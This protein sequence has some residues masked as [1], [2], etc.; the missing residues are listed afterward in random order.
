M[1]EAVEWGTT[2][3]RLRAGDGHAFRLGGPDGE[4]ETIEHKI[5]EH[6]LMIDQRALEA[7]GLPDRQ[8]GMDR[9][10]RRCGNGHPGSRISRTATPHYCCTSILGLPRA[11]GAG[12]G[13]RH[14]PGLPNEP[15]DR[16]PP[17]WRPPAPPA[18]RR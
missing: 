15:E 5:A 12:A 10:N 4:E 11:T 1:R 9:A 17:C 14:G 7:F 8:P 13:G 16:L 18:S 2:L 6:K 3:R